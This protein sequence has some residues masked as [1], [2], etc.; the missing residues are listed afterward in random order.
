MKIL[1]FLGLLLSFSY[2]VV[3]FAVGPPYTTLLQPYTQELKERININLETLRKEGLTA[4]PGRMFLLRFGHVLFKYTN[5]LTD[6]NKKD[7]NSMLL[8][9]A[10]TD[11]RS[12]NKTN[13]IFQKISIIA[14]EAE[15]R[16]QSSEEV[17]KSEVSKKEKD[18][19]RLITK[20]TSSTT[21]DYRMEQKMGLDLIQAREKGLSP[22]I[23]KYFLAIFK[24]TFSYHKRLSKE[25]KQVFQNILEDL[26]QIKGIP[27]E[28]TFI[29]TDA[30]LKKGYPIAEKVLID[31]IIPSSNKK[32]K[33]GMSKKNIPKNEELKKL[34][35]SN[36]KPYL[37]VKLSEIL[38]WKLLLRFEHVFFKYSN[39][40]SDQNKKELNSTLLKLAKADS[41]NLLAI[42][43]IF[44]KISIIAKEAEQKYQASKKHKTSPV[45]KE[46]GEL[47][48]LINKQADSDEKAEQDLQI[49]QDMGIEQKKK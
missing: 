45:S 36:L 41:T 14:K 2:S 18:A 46:E 7:L 48:Q 39:Y 34:F 1:W 31:F 42:D 20:H 5:Y 40:L 6:Q 16:Y 26:T 21:Y 19:L 49:K 24:A 17:G 35:N 22:F 43:N 3:S 44:Q 23:E 15:Q 25:E 8:K 33:T 28:A 47:L 12:L 11:S 37:K 38:E 27:S 29:Q 30:I 4:V 9:L 10:H 32:F 13:E